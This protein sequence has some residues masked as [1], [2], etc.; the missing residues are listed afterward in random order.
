M[1]TI[2]VLL[3]EVDQGL[4]PLAVS[5]GEVVYPP[6][7]R[8]GP[9][10]QRDVQ[11]VL[12]H[13]GRAVV[14]VDGDERPPQG[15]GSAGL[16]LPGHTERFAFADAVPTHHSW[17]QARLADPP[18]ALIARL[19]A[20]PAATPA[21]N[22]LAEL[23]REAVEV[24]RAPLPTAAPL[25]GAL[26]AAAI[27]RY[28]GDAESRA[29]SAETDVVDR[30]RLFIHE[31]VADT[32]VDL[33]AVAAAVH[34]TAPHLVRRFRAQ[35]GVTPMAYLWRRRV[36][37]GVD[38]LVHTGLPVGVVAERAGFKS[39]YHFSRRVREHTGLAPTALR[40]ERWAQATSR[41]APVSGS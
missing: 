16:L 29:R 23:V 35:L 15:P 19:G 3:S 11:L 18:P 37:T 27:W 10:W 20:L 31:H 26:A 7:G 14:R 1:A 24:A 17:L 41:S 25:L 22:A 4:R 21:S 28:A 12:V 32:G 40:R 2:R 33:A 30:A 13:S 5:A 6:G 36:A 34:V 8:L 38:L 39:V 9:R